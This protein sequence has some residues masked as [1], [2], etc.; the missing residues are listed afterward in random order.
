MNKLEETIAS[1]DFGKKK[2][3]NAESESNLSDL[4]EE[5]DEGSA[6]EVVSQVSKS[7]RHESGMMSK[8]AL[9]KQDQR[10]DL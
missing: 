3:N 4:N 8:A 10:E 2:K 5:D 1:G 9:K 7:Q 6:S